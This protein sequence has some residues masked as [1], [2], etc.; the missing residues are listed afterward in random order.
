MVLG[1]QKG[2]DTKQ[3]KERRFGMPNPEGYRK[4]QRLMEL[5]EVLY[6]IDAVGP[7]DGD[8]DTTILHVTGVVVGRYLGREDGAGAL[9]AIER[10]AARFGD[11]PD[12]ERLRGLVETA[13]GARS[14][15]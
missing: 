4:A 12:L 10:A 13:T 5:L 6:R 3:R 7:P 1:H 9:A 11:S 2:R 15:R 8:R 14:P